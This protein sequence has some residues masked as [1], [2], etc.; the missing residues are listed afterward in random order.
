[1]DAGTTYTLKYPDGTSQTG[2][3]FTTAKAG[4]YKL[5]FSNGC[6][7]S[8]SFEIK[9]ASINIA[10]KTPQVLEMCE[11]SPFSASL[12]VTNASDYELTWYKDGAVITGATTPNYS[13][14]STLPSDG[15]LYNVVAISP[16]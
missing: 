16:G 1:M 8:V 3:T 12:T 4:V 9:D 2:T 10:H 11:N 15:G 13:I 7:T 14:A 6:P 5:E